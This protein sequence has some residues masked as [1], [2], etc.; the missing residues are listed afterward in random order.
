[1]DTQDNTD[2][3][4]FLDEYLRNWKQLN[5][6]YMRAVISKDLI[7]REIR[8]GKANDY[9]YE[10]SVEGWTQTFEYFKDQEMEW[11]LTP[12]S[13]IPLKSNERIAIIRATITI[14]GKLVETSNLFFQ[15]FVLDSASHEWK[16]TRTYVETGISNT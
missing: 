10:G 5:S 8:Q 12:Q 16:L 9:G 7:G 4:S 1:L 6:E 14:D 2:F 3:Y 13:I 15:A 11:I